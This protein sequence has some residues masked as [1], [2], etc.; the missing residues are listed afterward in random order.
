MSV[1]FS[2]ININNQDINEKP[3]FPKRKIINKVV[4]VKALDQTQDSLFDSDI[5][6]DLDEKTENSDSDSN[7]VSESDSG[8]LQH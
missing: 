7:S 2:G 6:S 8:F 4:S 5:D 1:T 3:L